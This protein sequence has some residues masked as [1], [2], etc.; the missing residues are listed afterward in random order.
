MR[1][2]TFKLALHSSKQG[3]NFPSSHGRAS[4]YL[5]YLLVGHCKKFLKYTNKKEMGR[6]CS[7]QGSEGECIGGWVITFDLRGRGQESFGS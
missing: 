1:H 2:A 7:I 6:T 3:Y 5:E 4:L